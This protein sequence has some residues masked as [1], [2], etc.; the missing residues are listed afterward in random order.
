MN[1][2]SQFTLIELLVVIAIIAVLAALL[3]PA[4][5]RS[6]GMAKRASCAAQLKQIH[7]LMENY[8]DDNNGCFDYNANPG[9]TGT[10]IWWTAKFINPGYVSS[11]A[12]ENL[13]C[14]PGWEPT[15]W[16]SVP[17]RANSWGFLCYG[18]QSPSMS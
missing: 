3:L 2:K 7:L 1:S 13:V 16:A 12:A 9:S 15:K 10:N 4:L 11:K 14:C 6:K 18:I 17:E 8:L 5:A